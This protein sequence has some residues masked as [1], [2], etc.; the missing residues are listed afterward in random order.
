MF[1]YLSI[2]G[3]ALLMLLWL[4]FVIFS[5]I[6]VLLS[7]K[8]KK[9][10]SWTTMYNVGDALFFSTMSGI[11]ALVTATL[12]ISPGMASWS[13]YADIYAKV[14]EQEQIIQEYKTQRDEIQAT[15]ADFE[16]PEQRQQILLN[17]DSPIAST[18][19]ELSRVQ[20]ELTEA[21]NERARA[22]RDVERY[23]RGP[24]SGVVRVVG[25]PRE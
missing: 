21:K 15:L 16:Y 25:D 5:W 2:S 12:I 3:A 14:S 17:A 10:F 11:V 1:F 8:T 7:K 9:S 4:A 22:I 19:N 13:N 18:V 23:S 20:R 24:W 6:T